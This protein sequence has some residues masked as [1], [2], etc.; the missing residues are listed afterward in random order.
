MSDERSSPRPRLVKCRESATGFDLIALAD[1]TLEIYDRT[2][3]P[4]MV[5]TDVHVNL[6]KSRPDGEKR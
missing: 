1:F 5:A 2:G 6:V 3:Q 4:P